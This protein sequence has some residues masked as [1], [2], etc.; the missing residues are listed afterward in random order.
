MAVTLWKPQKQGV[1]YLRIRGGSGFL[2]MDMRTGKT[3]TTIE[4]LSLFE[5]PVL[6]INTLT[7]LDSWVNDLLLYGYTEDDFV[8][9]KGTAEQRKTKLQYLR[10]KFFLINYGVVVDQDVLNCRK[11]R[12]L[13]R[14][15]Q[16]IIFDEAYAVGLTTLI[17]Y[18]YKRE[19]EERYFIKSQL[20]S[21]LLSAENSRIPEYQRR[22]MLSGKP[23]P[24][25]DMNY[26]TQ[27]F[28]A[29]GRFLHYTNIYD[30]L[31]TEWVWNKFR[32]EW[33][34]RF[35]D[36][37]QRVNDYVSQN[38]YCVKFEDAQRLIT[39]KITTPVVFRTETVPLTDI[40]KQWYSWLET[41]NLY[42]P[43]VKLEEAE[44]R[45]KE[46]G[47]YKEVKQEIM[48]PIVKFT[49][50]MKIAAGI[51]PLTNEPLGSS[52]FEW[53]HNYIESN[54]YK[55]S[56]NPENR[57]LAKFVITGRVV[58]DLKAFKNY[59][60]ERGIPCVM[61]YGGTKEADREKHRTEFSYGD[62]HVFIGQSDTIC[63][64]YNLAVS[65][66]IINVSSNFSC[67][68][69]SQLERRACRADK[70]MPVG[71]IDLCCE[72]TREIGLVEILRNKDT[73]SNEYISTNAPFHT[74]VTSYG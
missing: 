18:Q 74:G 23:A 29:E 5:G 38:S 33:V 8:R 52:K 60:E 47:V 73:K 7:G 63:K 37:A 72:D 27:Y 16:F 4:Y 39:G 56:E 1:E 71:F 21:Y 32:F 41:N 11:N 34:P 45:F 26:C 20:I 49:Y 42:Q 50:G 61:V 3:L 19:I 53:V 10:P 12:L 67:D 36:H 70:D 6:I 17:F 31:S 58:D 68:V 14:D 55:P 30:Y 43:K 46:T 2:W 57:E 25:G 40:Q 22:I 24:E 35:P 51:N 44:K 69:R 59:L 65:D 62:A 13:Q 66:T 9:I 48:P 15:W 28:I 54:K 64:S